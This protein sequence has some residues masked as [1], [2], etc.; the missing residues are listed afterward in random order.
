MQAPSVAT[1]TAC[2]QAIDAMRQ[3]PARGHV[4]TSQRLIGAAPEPPR[5]A[6]LLHYSK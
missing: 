1:V 4:G 5:R 3:A 6:R 2:V